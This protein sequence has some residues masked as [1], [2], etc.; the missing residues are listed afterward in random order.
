MFNEKRKFCVSNFFE[1]LKLKHVFLLMGIFFSCSVSDSKC[2]IRGLPRCQ[3][4]EKKLSFHSLQKQLR[5][6]TKKNNI[7]VFWDTQNCIGDAC[8]K[9]NLFLRL[10]KPEKIVSVK[11]IV[12]VFVRIDICPRNVHPSSLSIQLFDP[13]PSPSYWRSFNLVNRFVGNWDR[14]LFEARDLIRTLS[15]NGYH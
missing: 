6:R 3:R 2:W 5:F 1:R 14:L 15:D 12:F 8:I 13:P 11:E 4:V 9:N 10:K 7:N